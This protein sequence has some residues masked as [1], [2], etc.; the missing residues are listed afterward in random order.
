MIPLPTSGILI[1]NTG[2]PGSLHPSMPLAKKSYC[3]IKRVDQRISI[4]SLDIWSWYKHNIMFEE[5]NIK[6][7]WCVKGDIDQHEAE[8]N[9]SFHTSINLDIVL[10]KHQLLC[11]WL[12]EES[13]TLSFFSGQGPLRNNVVTQPGPQLELPS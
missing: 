11:I 4:G 7:Y 5:H 3:L 12:S 2:S 8:V 1:P 10:F 13:W 6:I 9:I